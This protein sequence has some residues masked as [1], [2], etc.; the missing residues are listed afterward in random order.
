MHGHRLSRLAKG[1]YTSKVSA[2]HQYHWFG[3]RLFPVACAQDSRRYPKVR[4]M[5]FLDLV[6][7][8]LQNSGFFFTI[9]PV[10]TSTL[11]V[12][13]EIGDPSSSYRT[14][15]AI[16]KTYAFWFGMEP[17]TRLS[18][19]KSAHKCIP[20]NNRYIQNFIQIG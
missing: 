5:L 12:C 20:Y 15:G 17:P 3:V 9:A 16:T 7:P 10:F 1:T 14:S 8:T 2:F 18:R 13:D 4:K 11:T 19:S 6:P